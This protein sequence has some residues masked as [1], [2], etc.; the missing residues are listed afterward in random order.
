MAQ[1]TVG[2]TVDFLA[3]FMPQD[4]A[5]LRARF[6]GQDDQVILT[7]G[8]EALGEA[9]PAAAVAATRLFLDNIDRACLQALAGARKR[10][11]A[12][13]LLGLVGQLLAMAS[14]GALIGMVMQRAEISHN[15][16]ALVLAVIGFL[17][18]ALPLIVNFLTGT[19]TDPDGG[20]QKSFIELRDA[21]G[22]A[23]ELRQRLET[24]QAAKLDE[25]WILAFTA[26]VNIVARRMRLILVDLG[27]S[28]VP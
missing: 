24:Q 22:Q 26:E 7:A 17:S 5:A 20:L 14:C 21:S 6:P 3:R 9:D 8:G 12:A 25:A 15:T 13:R 10:L 19:I 18:G 1:I 27:Y 23:L 2:E 4:L 28:A 16:Q 11:N